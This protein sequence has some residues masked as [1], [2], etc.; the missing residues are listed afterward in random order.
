MEGACTHGYVM[1][2][3]KITLVVY[4]TLQQISLVEEI[5]MKELKLYG[6]LVSMHEKRKLKQV[7]EVKTRGKKKRR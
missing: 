3:E 5:E 1:Q 4:M 2:L 7:L 6:K